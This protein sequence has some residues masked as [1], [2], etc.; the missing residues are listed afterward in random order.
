MAGAVAGA[1]TAFLIVLVVGMG[2][3]QTPGA[4]G[5]LVLLAS[6]VAAVLGAVAG[7]YAGHAAV[8]DGIRRGAV[9]FGGGMAL[10]AVLGLAVL[11]GLWV[12]L[13]M[14][15]RAK[16]ER[17]RVRWAEAKGPMDVQAGETMARGLQDCYRSERT[18]ELATLAAGTCAPYDRARIGV[19]G[20]A[21]DITDQGW[22]WETVGLGNTRRIVIRPDPL[23]RRE[24]PLFDFGADGI[25]VTRAR[26]GAPGFAIGENLGLVERLYRCLAASGTLD[27]IPEQPHCPDLAVIVSRPEH[28]ERRTVHL[29]H[30]KDE[31]QAEYYPTGSWGGGRPEFHLWNS[32]RRYM[33][34]ADGRW[35][36]RPPLQKGPPTTEDPAPHACELDQ[37]VPCP[38]PF[39]R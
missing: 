10:V 1:F 25:L 17:D 36:V 31:E 2:G 27:A 7:G 6:G 3:D 4:F 22:R 33:L 24:G 26:D 35:H 30:G 39:S 38:A 32:G 14:P 21:Y 34:D 18:L 9:L 29:S 16:D 23:L 19:G 12:Y 8:R 13:R 15:G 37:N 5:I 28:L 20:T 11:A